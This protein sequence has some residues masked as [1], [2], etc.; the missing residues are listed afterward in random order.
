[1][2]LLLLLAVAV[3]VAAL[4][5]IAGVPAGRK[6]VRRGVEER[7]EE[8]NGDDDEK[9]SGGVKCGL[10]G[11][12]VVNVVA[13]K[14]PDEGV[15]EGE[16]E[17]SDASEVVGAERD[18]TGLDDIADVKEDAASKEEGRWVAGVSREAATAGEGEADAT[19]SL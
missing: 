17:E 10:K 1:M 13:G 3:A 4:V 5:E 16:G 6:V 14:R 18:V 8:E 7:W 12:P 19:G 15:R 2:V 11:L 9:E